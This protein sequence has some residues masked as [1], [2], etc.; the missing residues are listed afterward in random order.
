MAPPEK[1]TVVLIAGSWHYG[2]IYEPVAAILRAQGYPVEL[3]TLL[4]TGG[5]HSATA[6]DDA[7]HLRSTLLDGLVADGKEIIMVLHSYA[8]IP[9]GDSVK[10]LARKDLAAA[11]QRGGVIALVYLAAFLLPTGQSI[12]SA[13][14]GA[15]KILAFDGGEATMPNPA[16]RFYNDL[17]EITATKY[18]ARLAPYS[19]T[20]TIF[21]PVTYEAYR[22][23]PSI[24]LLCE[25]DATISLDAQKAMVGGAGEGVV[26]V[27]SCPAA[28]SPMLSSPKIVS[29]VID[30]AARSA[31]AVDA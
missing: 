31:V 21:S 25:N 18:V 8:G 27:Q 17:D 20:P 12:D 14:G 28:H 9:G 26:E 22:D 4:S 30:K 16:V 2:S 24:Y 5:P 11:G 10:G 3:V 15:D 29:D 13:V 1:P 23:I 7:A 6:A 19:A